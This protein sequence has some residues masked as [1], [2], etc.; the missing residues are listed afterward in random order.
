M[1]LEQ[2]ISVAAVANPRSNLWGVPLS[3]HVVEESEAAGVQLP[4]V[5]ALSPR[6]GSGYI[7]YLSS[8]GDRASVRPYGTGAS[9]L[10]GTEADV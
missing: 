3:D 9:I 6:F 2:Y 5:R 8:R 4:N 7:L 1:G 10:K